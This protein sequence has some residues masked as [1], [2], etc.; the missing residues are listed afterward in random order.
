MRVS[1]GRPVVPILFSTD[2]TCQS[3]PPRPALFRLGDCPYLSALPMKNSIVPPPSFRGDNSLAAPGTGG[4]IPFEAGP[5]ADEERGGSDGRAKL[6]R[7]WAAIKRFKWLV[8]ILAAIGTAAG[9]TATRFID[10]VYEARGAVWIA[11]VMGPSNGTSAAYR[12]PELLPNGAWVQLMK[13][14]KVVDDVV[15][16]Q[17]LF[18]KPKSWQDSIALKGLQPTGRTIGGTYTLNVDSARG[19]YTLSEAERGVVEKGALGDSVGRKVGFA[20]LP[21]LASLQ[22]DH[23]VHFVVLQPRAVSVDLIK[24]LDVAMQEN[25]NFL[26]LTLSGPDKW[27]TADLLNVWMQQFVNTAKELRRQNMESQANILADQKAVADSSMHAAENALESFRSAAITKPSEAGVAPAPLSALGGSEAPQ[28]AATSTFFQEQ[29]TYAQVQQD[30]KTV[31]DLAAR[32]RAGTFN[33]DELAAIPTIQSAPALTSAL[34]ELVEGEAKLRVMRQ[35]YTDDYKPVKDQAEAVRILREQTIPNMLQTQVTLLRQR[36][37]RLASM[38]RADSAQ[39]E[40]IPART[41]EEG[42]LRRNLATAENLYTN[43]ENRF[44]TA[45]LGAESTVPDVSILDPALPAANAQ[46]NLTLM[47]IAGG[48]FGA[49][50]L[51]VVIALLLDMIDH[52][53]RYPEQIAD[54]LGLEVLGAV[55]TVPKPG[56]A[57]KDPEAVLQSV[58]AF[59]A[60]RM[61]LHHEFDAPPVMV[62]ISSPGVGDGKSMIASNL[63]LSFAEAGYRT[64]LIDGDIRRGKL[65]SIF[66]V[67]RRPG[68]LDYLAGDVDAARIMHEL[69]SH[70]SLTLIPSGTRRQRGPELLTSARLPALLNM[71]RP[72]FDVILVDSAPLAAGVDAYALS[73]ATRSMILV[74]RTGHTDR[75][76][77]KA[78]LR[79]LERLPVR[80]LGAVVNAV[81][82]SDSYSEYSYLYGYG[83]DAD[84]DVGPIG[85]EV[86]VLQPGEPQ[87]S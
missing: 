2:I 24:R 16:S 77:A 7:Y 49:A 86:A 45:R 17:Q 23:E 56:D 43:V 18:L 50:A 44:E 47:L 25:S 61:N 8:I 80:I 58:E 29:T 35:Q 75:R 40:G 39:L 4:V 78:K 30:R 10:P 34:K 19:T 32:A 51:G 42:R 72:R 21:S 28:E 87:P 81:S 31:E 65:H 41:I 52:R 83:P 66:G 48:M 73:V 71:L 27:Q 64:L 12:P 85:D 57:D 69:P 37:A 14:F 63:A 53:F 67:D 84:A 26:T 20:W 5:H 6:R 38:I 76:V 68:L 3:R 54:E 55:P 33:V 13:S 36:E 70:G 1:I 15:A 62:T 60:L 82:T 9:I 74:M 11:D 46:R 79:L 22:G 59:R